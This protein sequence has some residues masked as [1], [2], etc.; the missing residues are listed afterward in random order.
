MNDPNI[1]KIKDYTVLSQA[2]R[3]KQAMIYITNSL[4][5]SFKENN[6]NHENH[7]TPNKTIGGQTPLGT[8]KN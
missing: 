6:S 5:N 1:Q 4:N 8:S 3:L 2:K 7:D